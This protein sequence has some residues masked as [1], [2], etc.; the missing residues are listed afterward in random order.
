M[1][2]RS[3]RRQE[4]PRLLRG[5]GAYV[6]DAAPPGALHLAVLR[7]PHAHA[8]IVA[9]DFTAARR[10]RGVVAVLEAKDVGTLRL[11]VLTHPPGQR[12]T[13]FPVLP[14]DRVLYVGQPVAAVVA[15]SR[16]VAE[17]ALERMRVE[18][19][20]LPALTSVTQATAPGAPR[21]YPDWPDN[22]AV[23][24]NI[25]APAP[26][27]VF[28]GA[29]AVVEMTFSMPRQTAAPLEG[30]A[31]CA[32][33][34]KGALTVWA[35]SQ[36]PHQYRTVLAGVL[37]L[38]E[39][40]IRVIVPD[41][42]GGFGAKLH[43]Y[44]D[45]LLACVAAM[46][47][48]RPVKWVEDRREHFVATVHAREQTVRA[49]AA[50]G[51]DGALLALDVHVRGDVGAHL[52]TK[53]AGPIFLGGVVLPGQYAIRHFH[54]RLEA[55]VTN[56]VPFGAYR[57]FGM[58]QA[59]FVLER[60]MDVGAGR[61][62]LDPAEI[63]RRNYVPREAFPFKNAAGMTYDSGDYRPTL[64][65][66]LAVADYAGLRAM[67][68]RERATGRLIGVGLAGY[69][70]VTGMGPS[71]LMAAMGNR[72]G[73]YETALVRLEPSG[74]ASV[75]TGIIELGQ[76]IR[77]S[78]AQVAAE[79]LTLPPER[80]RVVLGDTELCPYS[81]YG[82]ADSRGSVVGGAAV[83]QASRV[84]RDKLTRLAAHLLEAGVE[85]IELADGECRVRGVPGRA[86]S[87]A[88]LAAEAQR[89]GNLPPGADPGLDGRVTYH[90]ENWTHPYGV[91][92]A[93]VEVARETGAVSVLGYWVAHDCGTLL[94]PML[95]DGQLAGGVA[96]GL[97]GALLEHLP[98]DE[99]GQPLGRT[100][101]E[102]ALPTAAVMPP[103]VVAHLET[104]SPHTP[105]GMKGMAEGGTIAAPAAIGNAV[106]DALVPAGVD[107]SAIDFYPL[108]PARVFA[109]LRGRR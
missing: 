100:F 98:Y 24:R 20:P 27:G 33:F 92:V 99:S 101:M 30:R 95:V 96:Q 67:Q 4:D 68:T 89:G 50:F 25:G 103:L 76:G 82:T 3:L 26:D 108:T 69:V 6:T 13:D 57:G 77:T 87:L 58:Q 93:A 74:R 12:Q 19:A 102:Y 56:K 60:L 10:L 37:G 70:E 105:G 17:D 28:A 51:A 53:G 79:I 49:R 46:R 35:S 11:P 14:A 65:R 90:P 78:L 55:V 86:L 63:R 83:L 1:I 62:H 94:N 45:E 5:Q 2:G 59:A 48:G 91:H 18:Y 88:A 29:A 97:G 80:V 72:Q 64:E 39:D 31:I 9:T 66:A 23:A 22:V 109:L 36:A 61:L 81:C 73:G 52:H 16:Y 42:G 71:R 32:A 41:V 106:A 104:P 8:R 38:D 85:D 34:D 84:V 107:P 15:E 47:L 54:A 44:P 43:Y 40:R 75:F 21:L 7:S